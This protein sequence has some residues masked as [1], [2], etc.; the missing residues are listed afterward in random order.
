[1]AKKKV[2]LFGATGMAGHVVYLFLRDTGNYQVTPVVYRNKLTDDCV[3]ID[4]GDKDQVS[5]IIKSQNPDYI[6][7]CVGILIKGANQYPDNA[8]LIN[9]YFPHLLTKVADEVGARLIHISTDCVFSGKKGLYAENDFKDADDVYGRSKALGEIYSDNHLTLRTSIIGPELK[10]EGEGLFHWFM[11][12]HGQ[13]NGYTEAYW[14]GVTTLELANAIDISI[15]E[16]LT[17]T[18][19]LTNGE[20]ISKYNLLSLFKEVWNKHYVNVINIPGKSV[21]K[22]LKRSDKFNFQVPG[23]KQMLLDQKVW[24]IDHAYLYDEIYSG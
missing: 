15:K 20:K 3:I 22:S 14:G 7:N 17:G 16:N 5:N 13:I 9:S 1:M 18:V 2:L 24:M 11:M 21:D 4:A 8:I 6:I 19:H 10:K 12:Q 23:Y